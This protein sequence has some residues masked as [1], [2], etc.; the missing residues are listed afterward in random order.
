M[1][2]WRAGLRTLGFTPTSRSLIPPAKFHLLCKV[3]DVLIGSGEQNG[4]V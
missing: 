1:I 2:A 4:D 3:T